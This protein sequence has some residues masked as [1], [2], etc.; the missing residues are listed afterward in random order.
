[1]LQGG[2]LAIS[3]SLGQ[4]IQASELWISFGCAPDIDPLGPWGIDPLTVF[5]A[6]K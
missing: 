1:M 3:I 2:I 5:G 4:S 6:A